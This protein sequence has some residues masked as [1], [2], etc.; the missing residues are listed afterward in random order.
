MIITVNKGNAFDKIQHPFM[1]GEKIVNKV[2]IEENVINEITSKKKTQII[3][4]SMVNS[5]KL[6]SYD[7][8]QD[9]DAHF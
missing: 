5:Q 7:Q 9:K 1:I 8:E 3:L 4:C 6:F 2:G